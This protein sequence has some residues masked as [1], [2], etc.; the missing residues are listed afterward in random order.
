MMLTS[1]SIPYSNVIYLTDNV[2]LK[3]IPYRKTPSVAKK[4]KKIAKKYSI[5]KPYVHTP[6]GQ[7]DELSPHKMQFVKEIFI[8]MYFTKIVMNNALININIDC[9]QYSYMKKILLKNIS[10][11][12]EFR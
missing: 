5:S 10:F 9:M 7:C 3:I 8:L 2:V 11:K 4:Q 1:F 12:Y 6:T